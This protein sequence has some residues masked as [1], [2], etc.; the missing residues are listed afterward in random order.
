[1]DH[2][3]DTSEIGGNATRDNGGTSENKMLQ[4]NNFEGL[5]IDRPEH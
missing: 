2:D 1:M 5:S 4:H 3:L